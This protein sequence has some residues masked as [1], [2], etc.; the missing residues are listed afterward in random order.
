MTE[1]ELYLTK[2]RLAL[3]VAVEAGHILDDPRDG[4]TYW[5][6]PPD[7]PFR[8][9]ARVREAENAGWVELDQE[10]GIEWRLTEPGREL[11][12]QARKAAAR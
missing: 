10:A 6:E 3:L 8:V 5:C 4:H 11:L 1:G 2:T 12:A 9:D 7:E